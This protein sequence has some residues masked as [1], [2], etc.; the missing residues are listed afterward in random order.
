MAGNYCQCYLIQ[1]MNMDV[2][3]EHFTLSFKKLLNAAFLPCSL[4]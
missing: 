1:D 2:L 4:F 3:S